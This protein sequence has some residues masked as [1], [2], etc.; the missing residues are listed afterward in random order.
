MIVWTHI[1]KALQSGRPC[2]MV[3]VVSVEGS[4]P[5]EV[6]ARLVVTPQGFHGTIGG[7]SLEWQAV[8]AAQK[9]LAG[10]AGKTLSTHVLGV[11]LGQCCGGRVKLMTEVFA[12]GDL[13][14]VRTY[15]AHEA[16]GPFTLVGRIVDERFNEHFG[17]DR[18]QVYLFGAGHVGRAMILAL[19]PLPF[20]ITWVDP[21]KGAFPAMTPPHTTIVQTEALTAVLETPVHKS[22]VLVMTHSHALDLEVIDAALRQPRI[23]FTGLIGSET[24]RERFLHRLRDAGVA[25]TALQKLVCPI[26]IPGI[27]SKHPAAIAAATAAQILAKDE[28]LRS[29][30]KPL[31][32]AAKTASVA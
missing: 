14:E 2:A 6:G 3:S 12:A 24:K 32:P 16:E 25:E 29:A 30:S 26:G 7:G 17:E 20:K 11:E 23:A 13:E 18:R 31:A 21:R 28:L 19:A 27:A 9:L 5:R 8:A 10:G 15:A 4:A 22:F 1:A